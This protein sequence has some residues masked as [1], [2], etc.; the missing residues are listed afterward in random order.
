MTLYLG[1]FIVTDDYFR[2]EIVPNVSNLKLEYLTV[3]LYP[4]YHYY[5]FQ[6]MEE[7]FKTLIVLSHYLEVLNFFLDIFFF[8]ENQLGDLVYYPKF[9]CLSLFLL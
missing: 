1:L 9:I 3:Y 4:D 8:L 7:Q 5:I 2:F 6:Q